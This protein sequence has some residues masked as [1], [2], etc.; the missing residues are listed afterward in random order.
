MQ[1]QQLHTLRFAGGEQIFVTD[2][3]QSAFETI[4]HLVAE[5]S[6]DSG[7]FEITPWRSSHVHLTV[8]RSHRS[9]PLGRLRHSF[10]IRS[11][12]GVAQETGGT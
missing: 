5:S 9:A 7:S 1:E 3:A 8:L 6:P 4:R 12:V 2:A 11:A 10:G